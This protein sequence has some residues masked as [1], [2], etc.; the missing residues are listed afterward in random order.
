M[1]SEMMPCPA[2]NGS[3]KQREDTRP[4]VA[5][6]GSGNARYPAPATDLAR[7]AEAYEIAAKVADDFAQRQDRI[8]TVDQSINL[9]HASQATA[10]REIARLIREMKP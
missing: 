7:L 9:L 3:G 10:A 4:C 1:T 8:R 6:S 2:C 5:C